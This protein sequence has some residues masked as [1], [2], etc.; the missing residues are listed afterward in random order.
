MREAGALEATNP[1]SGEA[2]P[3]A[4]VA[5]GPFTVVTDIVDDRR[6]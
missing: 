3:V 5:P 6:W 1:R 2:R 4:E